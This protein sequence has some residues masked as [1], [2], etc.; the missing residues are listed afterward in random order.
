MKDTA[1]EKIKRKY[2]RISALYDA[3]I[4]RLISDRWRRIAAA[5]AYGAVLEIGIGSG[6]NLPF[7]TERCLRLTGIDVSS[8]MLARAEV[9]AA[10]CNFPVE[11]EKMDVQKLSFEESCFDTV[12]SAFVFCT[13]PEPEKGLSECWRV[14]KPGGR[15]ILLEHM[16]SEK[17]IVRRIMN[18]FAPFMLILLRDHINRDTGAKAAEAGFE[19][20]REIRLLGDVVR[21]IVAAK[22]CT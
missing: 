15:L 13:V 16:S 21:L 4:K 2:D 7:Y 1:E 22:R 3:V 17:P 20:E 11:L 8:R 14:L 19:T 9:R 5:S 12:L 10:D 6:L 18:F